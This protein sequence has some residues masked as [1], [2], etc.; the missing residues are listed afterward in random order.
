MTHPDI[1]NFPASLRDAATAM[2]NIV[3]K[4]SR[5]QPLMPRDF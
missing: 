3:I 2:Q 1:G 4:A 5:R